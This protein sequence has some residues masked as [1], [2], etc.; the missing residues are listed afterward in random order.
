MG[1]KE[2]KA[3]NV[4][5]DI[6]QQQVQKRLEARR[7]G[8]GGQIG[9]TMDKFDDLD[10]ANI[11]NDDEIDS[12]NECFNKEDEIKY[13]QFF[14]KTNN[15]NLHHNETESENDGEYLDLS[16]MLDAQMEGQLSNDDSDIEINL[17]A[18]KRKR[19]VE[20][21]PEEEASD[22]D[23]ELEALMAEESDN[24]INNDPNPILNLIESMD[25][26]TQLKKKKRM[27][28]INEFVDASEFGLA[29]KTTG[30]KHI[31][32]DDLL[33]PIS[34]DAG[35]GKLKK[36][37]GK[38]NR[39]EASATVEAPL[40]IRSQERMNRTAAY[41][42]SKKAISKWI[43]IIKKNREA[44]QI[45]F[46]MNEP[47]PQNISSGSLVNK[48]KPLTSMELEINELLNTSGLTEQKQ[49]ESEELELN[50]VSPEEMKE[51]LAQLSKMR[52]LMFYQEQ[53]QKKI[54]KIKSKTY[55]KIHK[56][57]ADKEKEEFSEQIKL[58]DPELLQESRDKADFER[59]KERMTLKHKN[60][61]KW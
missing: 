5:E 55:R 9:R 57:Q 39:I 46:P 45:S 1:R 30:L 17:D 14:T 49:K 18:K 40:P 60:T 33:G 15:N 21:L 20:L 31:G 50:I 24:D 48:F 16:Q 6:D 58:L 53:K 59:I 44:D 27:A 51:R 25:N 34:L 13:G 35:F 37:M 12:D 26:T 23:S 29:S 38:L 2:R 52:S 42:E 28:E 3:L 7:G 10:F 47:T 22:V 54:A 11:Q 61:G 32:L 4:Y 41:D 19:I 43:P 36:Q 8:G 56:K